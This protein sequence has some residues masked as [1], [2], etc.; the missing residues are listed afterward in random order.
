MIGVELI[1][2]HSFLMFQTIEVL[3][4]KFY[5]A[6]VH[7]SEHVWVFL[8]VFEVLALYCFEGA[9][10]GVIVRTDCVER[11]A[12]LTFDVAADVL[13]AHANVS[14]YYAI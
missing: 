4:H 13:V 14:D 10:G 1:P 12:L 3:I 2:H 7:H 6:F 5:V 9:L 11:G 8:W